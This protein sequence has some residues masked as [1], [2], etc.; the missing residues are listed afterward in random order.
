[1]PM[2]IDTSRV[3]IRSKDGAHVVYVRASLPY[4]DR[5]A[6]MEASEKLDATKPA[7]QIRLFFIMLETAIVAWE[8][9]EFDGL[10]VTKE[11]IWRMDP[12][13]PF[14]KTVGETVGEMYGGQKKAPTAELAT[15]NGS[16]NTGTA[17]S[18]RTKR[19]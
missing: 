8:G 5:L 13:E 4:G 12:E 1:M 2:F 16:K 7:D 15:T 3:P 11:N 14:W 17:S 9:P 19:A 6:M 10:P 18:T